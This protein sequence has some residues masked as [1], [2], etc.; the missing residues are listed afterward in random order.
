MTRDEIDS[1]VRK[2]IAEH[3]TVPV[4]Q[5]IDAAKI[6][7]DLGGDSLDVVEIHMSLDEEFNIENP[8]D[9]E[10]ETVTVKDAIDAVCKVMGVQ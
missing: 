6:M 2:I 5:V 3:L 7:D 10:D 8:D 9:F 4:D 1:R